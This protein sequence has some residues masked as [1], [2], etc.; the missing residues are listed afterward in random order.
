MFVICLM[1]TVKERDNSVNELTVEKHRLM[2]EIAALKQT[3][4]N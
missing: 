1:Q 2:D 3:E 4:V